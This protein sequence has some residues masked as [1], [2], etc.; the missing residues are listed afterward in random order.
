MGDKTI[1]P[2]PTKGYC[3]F[4]ENLI[5]WYGIPKI[6]KTTFGSQ[7][8]N[9]LFFTTEEGTKHVV[10][11]EWKIKDWVHFCER[12]EFLSKHIAECPYQTI[13]VDTTDN[14]TLLCEQFIAK[15]LGVPTIND[16]EYGKGFAA[17]KREMIKQIN[18]LT[19]LGLGVC[20]VSHAEE[21]TVRYD[22]VVNPYAPLMANPKGELTMMVPTLDKRARQFILGLVD[23]IFYMEVDKDQKRII[24]TKPTKHFE[25]GDRSGRLPETLTLDYTAVVSAYYST[26]G[27]P[28]EEAKAEIIKR[29]N[30]AE[31]YLAQHQIDNFDQPVRVENSRKK[32]LLTDKFEDA[33][34]ARLEGYLQHLRIKAKNAK[35][36]KE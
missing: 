35:K 28:L 26:D 5:L 36:E 30:I 33:D 20:F 9:A 17:Y 11:H 18:R 25:A 23:M 10:V 21:K 29:L 13:I 22:T 14:L 8:P 24:R 7:F 34:I 16:A 15:K 1:W 32:H 4:H 3:N 2:E 19:G 27:K 12:V 31:Q 6:G